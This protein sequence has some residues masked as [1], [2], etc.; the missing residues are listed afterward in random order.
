MIGSTTKSLTT[1]LMAA[2][3]DAGAMLVGVAVALAVP[4]LG[5]IVIAALAL[6][7]VERASGLAVGVAP[8]GLWLRV[9]A[10]L[11]LAAMVF[12]L[13]HGLAGVVRG[14]PTALAR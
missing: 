13:A 4:V 2:V 10:V 12:A 11:A 8:A 9:G 1:L 7:A 5:A 6:G 14:L 3:L